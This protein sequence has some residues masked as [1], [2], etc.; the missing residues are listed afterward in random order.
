MNLKTLIAETANRADEIL[1]GC[2]NPSEAQSILLELLAAEQ[3]S[4]A[5]ADRKKVAGEVTVI[6]GGEGFFKSDPGSEGYGDNTD[7]DESDGL[8]EDN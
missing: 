3:P 8:A 6:L 5:P 1:D 7:E 2:T 4:L